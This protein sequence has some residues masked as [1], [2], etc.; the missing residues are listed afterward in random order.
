VQPIERIFRSV[1]V[2]RLESAG[3]VVDILTNELEGYSLSLIAGAGAL[4]DILS[5]IVKD[6]VLVIEPSYYDADIRSEQKRLLDRIS[7]LP[8]FGTPRIHVFRPETTLTLLEQWLPTPGHVEHSDG[9]QSL[10][11]G[12][13][14]VRQ[15]AGGSV[16]RTM[17]SPSAFI[18]GHPHRTRC[19]A[20]EEVDFFG[21]PLRVEAV[22][23]MQ[24]D[25][26]VVSCFHVCLW[27]SAYGMTLSGY[28]PRSTSG[29][30]GDNGT[31]SMRFP[32]RGVATDDVEELGREL[33]FSVRSKLLAAYISQDEFE[34]DLIHHLD[35]GLPVILVSDA[36][37]P[38]PPE[39]PDVKQRL[40]GAAAREDLGQHSIVICGYTRSDRGTLDKL[41]Y[42]DDRYGPYLSAEAPKGIPALSEDDSPETIERQDVTLR[43]LSWGEK[44]LDA[45]NTGLFY[46]APQ[47]IW[48]GGNQ[49]AVTAVDA[50]SAFC[51]GA[52][53]MLEG[54]SGDEAESFTPDEHAEYAEFLEVLTAYV[55]M[56][57]NLGEPHRAYAMLSVD[58]KRR[59]SQLNSGEPGIYR[60]LWGRSLPR[61]IWVVEWF[62]HDAW[63]TDKTDEPCVRAEAVLDASSPE[64]EER[65]F[66]MRS[67]RLV[68]GVSEGQ[69][70]PKAKWDGLWNWELESFV[71]D[72]HGDGTTELLQR[73]CRR[74]NYAPFNAPPPLQHAMKGALRTGIS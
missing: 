23:F 1:D 29:F 46:L 62:D 65:V 12:Y 69:G 55:H 56:W 3:D 74:S 13:I 21:R 28:L 35:S 64:A 45:F 68:A 66:W 17:L 67:G 60:H 6:A 58:Y 32:N 5:R 33:G 36:D 48:L 63:K 59:Y 10:Y 8:S 61:Y 41:I 71:D 57:K 34:R 16:G 53:Q 20:V 52:S 42:H 54:P 72:D 49:A 14:V 19:L 2:L 18:T 70:V 9:L 40:L 37:P 43:A 25:G 44:H 73:S 30:I 27:M 24:Q 22:P 39:L 7:T 26:L 51:R 38:A 15:H 50:A 11:L 47:G 31:R 4:T